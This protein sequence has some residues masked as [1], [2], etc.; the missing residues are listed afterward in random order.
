MSAY[1]TI[2]CDI[3]DKESLLKALELLNLKPEVF[4]LPEYLF[5]YMGD[6]RKETAHIIIR[7]FEIN[8]YTGS[9]NDIGFKWNGEKYEF[10]ISE[11]D[12]RCSMDKR[13]IQA[14]VKVVLE[15]S[16]RKNG[17]KI[18][19]NINDELLQQKKLMD[20]DIVARKII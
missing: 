20:L 9:S 18:K 11:Y 15:E 7:R 10:I 3:V 4:E 16:L 17:F 13:I 5:G 6:Q 14:Y 19:I 1:K 12:K 8:K 2:E